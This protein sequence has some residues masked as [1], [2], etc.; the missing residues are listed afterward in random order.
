MKATVPFWI[1]IK[2]GKNKRWY[3]A[4]HCYNSRIIADCAQ[5]NGYST[6]TN[7]A[8]AARNM[9]KAVRGWDIPIY[10]TWFPKKRRKRK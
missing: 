7:A 10:A 2:Q 4:L 5:G 1:Q 3:W 8:K 6:E 9:L